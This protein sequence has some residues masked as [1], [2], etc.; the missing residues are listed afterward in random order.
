MDRLSRKRVVHGNQQV[1]LQAMTRY[2]IEK[3]G[4]RIIIDIHSLS[5]GLNGF[6]EKSG[7]DGWVFNENCLEYS[8]KAVD[9]E[10]SGNPWAFTLAVINEPSD[11]PAAFATADGLATKGVNWVVK[12]VNE[13]IARAKLVN[14]G[15][16]IMLQDAF[17]GEAFWSPDFD[18][19]TNLVIDSHI[20]YFI[21][22][23]IHPA[24]VNYSICGEASVVAGDGK[25]P[26]FIGE[27]S[28]ALETNN[29]LADRELL[30]NTQRWV[31]SNYASGSSFWTANHTGGTAI[32][33]EGTIEDYWSYLP[34]IDQ[35]VIHK[36]VVG[37]SY[38]T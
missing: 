24:F 12:Y 19:S 25:F 36:P 22:S 11:N 33:G 17:L 20:Y 23:G 5:G 21:Q 6:D 37:A 8:Y 16:V 1:Y 14:P 32:D 7:H 18:A 35:G 34:L 26:A 27:W 15:I 31:W 4:M 3:H 10:T 13:C 9:A 29:T 38:C 2:A 28:L 30:F